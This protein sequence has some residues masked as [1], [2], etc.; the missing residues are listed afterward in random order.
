MP[1]A[2]VRSGFRARGQLWQRGGMGFLNLVSQVR[3]LPRAPHVV[4][5]GETGAYKDATGEFTVTE[6]ETKLCSV[7]PS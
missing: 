4:V 7:A 3:I 5:T 1:K 6:T 2:Q